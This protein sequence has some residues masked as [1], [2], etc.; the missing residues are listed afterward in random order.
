MND[1]AGARPANRKT[2]GADGWIRGDW[3]RG[4]RAKAVSPLRSAT[5]VQKTLGDWTV[6]LRRRWRC[7]TL[8]R[9]IDPRSD[10]AG[11]AGHMCDA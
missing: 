7:A 5:A 11:V 8:L 1:E 9:V 3:E 2:N 4:V 10:G 6:Q